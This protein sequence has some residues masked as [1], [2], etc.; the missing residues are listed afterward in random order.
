[1]KPIQIQEIQEMNE[2]ILNSRQRVLR[3]HLLTLAA[4]EKPVFLAPVTKLEQAFGHA[5][6]EKACIGAALR[7]VKYD[8][9]HTYKITRYMLHVIHN[10]HDI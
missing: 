6:A 9:L 1:M 8:L 4:T 5:T 3:Y 7:S 2:S 10:I